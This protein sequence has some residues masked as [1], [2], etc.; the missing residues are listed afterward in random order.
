MTSEQTQWVAK[1]ALDRAA[2]APFGT[3]D[4][5]TLAD[6]YT[7]QDALVNAVAPTRGGIAGYKLAVNGA[8]QMAHFG[9]SEPVC[10]RLFRDEIH[11]SG[12]AL[13][14]ASFGEIAIEPELAAILGPAVA[15]L[16]G[17][18]DYD[19]ARAAIA[20][21][22]GAIELVDQRGI[23]MPS[24]QLQQ[25]VALNVFNAGIVLGAGHIAP[26]DPGLHDITV[27]LDLDG[28]HVAET[29]GTAPQDPI[30]AVMW[31]LN[32]LQSRGIAVAPGMIVMCGTHMPLRPLQDG[33][34]NVAFQMSKLGEIAFSLTP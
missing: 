16:S 33:T 14:R 21:F 8:A 32:H 26:D 20:R 27:S 28:A 6:G 9:V 29:T 30:D 19:G 22:H 7:L 5:A 23:V 25:A 2:V 15:D 34:R 18:V 12:I 1:T 11:D 24:V 3:V 10:A 13:P 31:L 4:I 17:P